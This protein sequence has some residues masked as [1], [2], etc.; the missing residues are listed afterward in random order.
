MNP[1]VRIESDAEVVTITMDARP[2]P[3]TVDVGTCVALTAALRDIA[4]SASARVVILRSAGSV[5]SAGGD[6]TYIEQAMVDPQR[7]LAP[8]IDSFHETVMALRYL[9]QPVIASVHGATAG[10]G[11]SLA[12]ACDTVVAA[13]SA[14]FV[15]DYPQIGASCDG[16]LSFQLAKRL[17]RQRALDVFLRTEPL[18]AQAAMD[19]GLVDRVVD[20][21]ALVAKTQALAR[22]LA[23]F[24]AQPVREI[25]ALLGHVADDGLEEQLEREK[26]AFLRCA[27][28]PEFAARVREFNRRSAK[29]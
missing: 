13:R 10:A 29:R 17:G 15:V 20:D 9:P 3:S 28:T 8:L 4:K 6:L 18:G 26:D 11:F 5:F 1:K 7:L 19:L 12:M 2:R 27:S 24:P 16:G 22:Q 14:R 21:A 23:D 25:K